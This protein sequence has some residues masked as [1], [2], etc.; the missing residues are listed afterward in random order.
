MSLDLSGTATRLLNRLAS[1]THVKIRRVT[2]AVFDPVLGTRTGG[3]ETVTNLVAAVTSIPENLLDD[4]R[5]QVGDKLVI[6]DNAFTPIMSDLVL[7]PDVDGNDIEYRI[8][9]IDGFNHAGVQQFW[10]LVC[11]G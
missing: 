6:A 4:T 7:I 2:G 3:T 1:N 11:R 10:R 8:I 9:T 5:I